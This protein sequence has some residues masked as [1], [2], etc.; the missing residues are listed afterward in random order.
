MAA[1]TGKR[2][3]IIGNG[4][5]GTYAAETI[6]KNLPDSDVTLITNEPYPLYNRVA[7]PPY[8][9]GTA[10][11]EKVFLRTPEQH[12]EKGIKLL[13]ETQIERIDVRGKVAHSA[14]GREL[15]YDQMLI[16]TGGR[17][18]ALA[19]PGAAGT[20]GVLNFQYFADAEAIRERMETSKHA[21]VVGGSYIAYELAEAFR[22][23]N[24]EVTWL[25]R[26]PRFLRRVLDEAGGRLVDQ[27]ARDAGVDIRYGHEV[28]E[29]H[30]R[31]GQVVGVTTTADQ[32]IDTDLVGVGLGV[33]MN[34]EFLA[35]TGITVR[36]GI[37]TNEF[38]ETAVPGVL[39]AGDV[40]EFFDVAIGLHNQMG[41]WNNSVG[42]GRIA[43]A[44]MSGDRKAYN[45]TPMYSTG[46]FDSRI[47]VM[48]LTPENLSDL[49]SYQEIDEEKRNYR[50]LFF[51]DGRLVGGCLIGDIKL[52]TKIIQVI[53]ARQVIPDS[54]RAS[55]LQ[56]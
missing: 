18:N 5:S 25:I 12:A 14:D 41:T 16:A 35:D 40:A 20:L 43:G 7:L 3:V 26:G 21:T 17:P 46:L 54:E 1:S 38:L 28:K 11:R 47:R 10:K 55:I 24:L 48:G 9:R 19:V 44:T 36:G 27:I 51:R 13:L 33:K 32:H 4:A 2:F 29:V 52:Q 56:S 34:T 39:A 6:R 50:R 45:D 31:D 49:E 15:P 30:A 23:H 42:H 22:H 37:V 53:Q 8:L